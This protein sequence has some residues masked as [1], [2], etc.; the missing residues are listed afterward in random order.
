MNGVRFLAFVCFAICLLN[1]ASVLVHSSGVAMPCVQV[2]PDVCVEFGPS[3]FATFA[4]F[5]FSAG[6][7]L[8]F[9][10]YAFG[11]VEVIARGL[12]RE[13]ADEEEA[14]NHEQRRRPRPAAHLRARRRVIRRRR[15]H[16]RDAP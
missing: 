9:A 4:G 11:N 2:T 5:F 7:F 3:F 16:S 15:F 12:A 6:V 1:V 10:E 8:L 13:N 14:L